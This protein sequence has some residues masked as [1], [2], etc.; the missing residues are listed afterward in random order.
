MVTGFCQRIRT[1][2]DD[3][4]KTEIDGEKISRLGEAKSFEQLIDKHLSWSRH[5][6]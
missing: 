1:Q 4:I 3:Q 2:V 6:D 5:I